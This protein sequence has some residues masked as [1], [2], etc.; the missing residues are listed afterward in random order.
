MSKESEPGRIKRLIKKVRLFPFEGCTLAR[1]DGVLTRDN[2]ETPEEKKIVLRRL[3]DN[4][5][6][7][8]PQLGET[9]DRR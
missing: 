1:L 2:M 7:Q 6:D 5:I 3:V 8:N 9:G 4:L